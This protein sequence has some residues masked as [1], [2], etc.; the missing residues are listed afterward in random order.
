MRS[1]KKENVRSVLS[2]HPIRKINYYTYMSN[3]GSRAV[4]GL[5]AKEDVTFF[6]DLA[7]VAQKAMQAD[8][9]KAMIVF[10]GTKG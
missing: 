7:I 10:M 3:A 6:H 9:E 1:R 2:I 4:R 5:L 8:A